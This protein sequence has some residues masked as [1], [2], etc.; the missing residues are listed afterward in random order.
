MFPLAQSHVAASASDAVCACDASAGSEVAAGIVSSMT[1]S[2]S[3]VV[4]VAIA[5]SG[6]CA[7]TPDEAASD[8]E[9]RSA[10]PDTSLVVGAIFSELLDSFGR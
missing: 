2:A 10:A 7:V 4:A 3:G 6:S 8:G 9:T 1:P 5:S